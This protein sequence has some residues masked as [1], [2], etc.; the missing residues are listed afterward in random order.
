LIHIHEVGFCQDGAAAMAAA[1]AESFCPGATVD[2]IVSAS[3]DYLLKTSGAEMR[4]LIETMVGRAKGAG[5]FE[6]FRAGLYDDAATYFRAVTCD[7]RETVPITIALF[8]LAEGDMEKC[9]VYGA[10]FGRDADTIASMCCAIGGAYKGIDAI[11][12]DW[13]DKV[14]KGAEVD[15]EE[16]AERL[17]VT[18][19]K[20]IE[21]EERAQAI[22][23]SICIESAP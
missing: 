5:D 8:Y 12:S 7:S 22:L 3:T 21:H 2:S 4:D 19:V 11:K 20:K 10:N 16:L 23:N 6:S 17:A 9:A 18:A 13:V 1:V 14:I 15:Q